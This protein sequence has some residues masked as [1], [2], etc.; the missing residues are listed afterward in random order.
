LDHDKWGNDI[1]W[2][3]NICVSLYTHLVR[4]IN[5]R[6]NKR[7][8]DYITY[9]E[10][11]DFDI[12]FA[13]TVGATP[14]GRKSGDTLSKGLIANNGQD[15][16]GL[17]ALINSVTKLPTMEMLA[18]APFD[19]MIH[20]SVIQGE[21]GLTA[22]TGILRTFFAQGGYSFMGNVMDAQTMLK[23]QKDPGKYQNLQVRLCGWNVHFNDLLKEQQ[24]QLIKQAAS[25]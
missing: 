22:M 13:P 6:K 2:V 18:G 25:L 24:D 3:D 12:R 1:E 7:G 20:P 23:A 19:Y 15:R 8:G 17:T 16:A 10:T 14:D 4:K 5:S 11:I 21:E 9:G